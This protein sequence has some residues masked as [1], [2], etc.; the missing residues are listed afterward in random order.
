MTRQTSVLLRHGRWA[1]LLESSHTLPAGPQL[2]ADL[3]LVSRRALELRLDRLR[4]SRESPSVE[5]HIHYS[6]HTRFTGQLQ[7]LSTRT[8]VSSVTQAVLSVTPR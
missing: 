5:G 7:V 2:L 6:M 4:R 3:L 1:H 8:A